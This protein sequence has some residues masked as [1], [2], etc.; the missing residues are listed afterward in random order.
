M[1][2]RGGSYPTK[3]KYGLVSLSDDDN[4]DKVLVG[5]NY[6]AQARLSDKDADQAEA[7]EAD[8]DEQEFLRRPDSEDDKE[9]AK[10]QF[11]KGNDN[12]RQVEPF[13]NSENP[14]GFE[15]GKQP[16]FPPAYDNIY[17]YLPNPYLP[18]YS[19]NLAPTLLNQYLQ[20]RSAY[21][22]GL[23]Y[24]QPQIVS[25]YSGAGSYGNQQYNPNPSSYGSYPRFVFVQ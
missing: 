22:S 6:F 15:F 17:N 19:Y 9:Y 7:D 4:E 18:P 23:R 10:D 1:A 21:N 8:A 13:D 20:R 11:I 12:E 3:G 25:Q 14:F 16:I 2:A 5:P 24:Q